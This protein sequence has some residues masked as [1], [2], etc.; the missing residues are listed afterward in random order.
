LLK[1]SSCY[2]VNVDEIFVCGIMWDDAD[3][4]KES[5]YIKTCPR[6]T[7]YTKTQ[8]GLLRYSHAFKRYMIIDILK[9]CFDLESILVR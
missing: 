6:A 3:K 4:G 2:S 8:F 9:L 7:L 5:I 1:I